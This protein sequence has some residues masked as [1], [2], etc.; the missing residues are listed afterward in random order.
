MEEKEIKNRLEEKSG[1]KQEN[2]NNENKSKKNKIQ[3][4]CEM[5]EDVT[6]YGEF[7]SSYF[8]WI[9]PSKQKKRAEELNKMTKNKKR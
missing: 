4:D 9:S 5:A 3:F 2:Q 1:Y 8:A 6:A 7:I